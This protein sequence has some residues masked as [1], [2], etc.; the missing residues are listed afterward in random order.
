MTH[1]ILVSEEAG[2]STVGRVFA[3]HVVNPGPIPGTEAPERQTRQWRE[4]GRH[5]AYLGT[6]SQFAVQKLISNA[7]RRLLELVLHILHRAQVID[8]Q[9]TVR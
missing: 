8:P 4:V 5:Q 3:L 9:P 1:K 7:L 2:K 6:G